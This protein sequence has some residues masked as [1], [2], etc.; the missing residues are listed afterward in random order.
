MRVETL[1]AVFFAASGA[2]RVAMYGPATLF[3][4]T[5]T[6]SHPPSSA[7]SD[8]L[9]YARLSIAVLWLTLSYFLARARPWARHVV[10]YTLLGFAAVES[11]GYSDM[12]RFYPGSMKWRLVGEAMLEVLPF[13]F[14]AALLMMPSARRALPSR[15][16][17]L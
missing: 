5:T 9:A 8:A 10:F 2:L 11:A 4:D 13:L 1:I 16:E 17:P 12:W 14:V 7:F 3:G 6:I 15:H